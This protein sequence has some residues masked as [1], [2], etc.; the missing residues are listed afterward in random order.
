MTNGR[1]KKYRQVA[2]RVL[3]RW[4]ITRGDCLMSSVTLLDRSNFDGPFCFAAGIKIDFA[5]SLGQNEKCWRRL[6]L[7]GLGLA[8]TLRGPRIEAPSNLLQSPPEEMLIES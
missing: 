3:W 2:V 4:R 7:G 6:G 1:I 8:L 5:E